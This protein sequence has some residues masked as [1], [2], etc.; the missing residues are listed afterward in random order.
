MKT[1]LLVQAIRDHVVEP[2]WTV[3]ISLL[4][5]QR[6]RIYLLNYSAGM[7]FNGAQ[8]IYYYMILGLYP[9]YKKLP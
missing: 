6:G 2:H 4:K 3:A 9:N 1:P 7:G 5:E 8:M